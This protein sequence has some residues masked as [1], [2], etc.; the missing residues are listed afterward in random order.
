MGLFQVF[1]ATNTTRMRRDFIFEYCTNKHSYKTFFVES[2]CYDEKII[3]ANIKV[4][5][6]SFFRSLE[7]ASSNIRRRS[8]WCYLY[9]RCFG[10]TLH[11]RTTKGN[12]AP[13]RFFPTK[14]FLHKCAPSVILV[15]KQARA[16]GQFSGLFVCVQFINASILWFRFLQQHSVSCVENYMAVQA[17]VLCL[18][19]L[20]RW[21]AQVSKPVCELFSA[22]GN[23]I[24]P[25]YKLILTNILGT[26]P[27]PRPEGLRVGR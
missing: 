22:I 12:W 2:V 26:N 15:W 13:P 10:G 24:C 16:V 19:S 8:C 27:V 4:S 9:V 6:L 20:T 18:P 1:D 17:L 11:V 7:S 14:L 25:V 3:E 21:P 5:A 23:T